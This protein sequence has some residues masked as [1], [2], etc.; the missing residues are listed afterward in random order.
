MFNQQKYEQC[1]IDLDN[2]Y[3]CNDDFM[4]NDYEIVLSNLGYFEVE[5]KRFLENK[6]SD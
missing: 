6:R 3:E 4:E 5:R 2:N 1:I